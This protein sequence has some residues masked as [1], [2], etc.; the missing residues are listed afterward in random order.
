MLLSPCTR[1]QKKEEVAP[2]PVA[3]DSCA[4]APPK[5]GQLR[6]VAAKALLARPRVALKIVLDERNNNVQ[7]VPTEK[8]DGFPRKKRF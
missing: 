1:T 3:V 7:L 5:Q 2:I 6:L 4:M 8:V